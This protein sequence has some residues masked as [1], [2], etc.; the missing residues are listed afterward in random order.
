M[1][2]RFPCMSDK[3][4]TQARMGHGALLTNAVRAGGLQRPNPAEGDG[5]VN[6]H[7]GSIRSCMPNEALLIQIRV[8]DY[9]I[10]P[11]LQRAPSPSAVY[12]VNLRR[13]NPES[14]SVSP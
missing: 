14:A 5:G 1:E 2:E 6:P 3:A 11:I 4:N 10:I 9:L 12:P 8:N 7:C 13:G